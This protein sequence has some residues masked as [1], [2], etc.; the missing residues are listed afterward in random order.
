M[1]E[2]YRMTNQLWGQRRWYDV[3]GSVDGNIGIAFA[4]CL[5]DRMLLVELIWKSIVCVAE[6][7]IRKKQSLTAVETS[8]IIKQE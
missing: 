7:D 1:F 3:S 4:D 2:L 6:A 5:V 8:K